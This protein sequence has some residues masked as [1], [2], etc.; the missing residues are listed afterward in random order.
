[1]RVWVS[2]IVEFCVVV[3]IDVDVL[4]TV[5]VVVMNLVSKMDSV[6]KT[7]SVTW[8]VTSSVIKT[9]TPALVVVTVTM[10]GPL[11]LRGPRVRVGITMSA[12]VECPRVSGLGC[13]KFLFGGAGEC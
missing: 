11:G 7:V 1:M 6:T 12:M 10:L 3:D 8:T 5:V 2:V 9:V 4:V 13:L